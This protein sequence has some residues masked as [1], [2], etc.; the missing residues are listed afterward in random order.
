M[1]DEKQLRDFLKRLE[2]AFDITEIVEQR[3]GLADIDSYYHQS[4]WAYALIHSLD[5][6][7]HMALS[8][9]EHFRHEDYLTQVNIV[10]E[11]IQTFGAKRILELGTGKGFNLKH[12][13][14]KFPTS[15]FFGLDLSSTHI[16][17]S[18]RKLKPYANASVTQAD[19]HYIPHPKHSF[20]YIFEFESICHTLDI[21]KSLEDIHRVLSPSGH[22]TLFDGFRIHKMSALTQDERTAR[23]L[24]EKTLGVQEGL[25]I[26]DFCA[27]AESVGFKVILCDNLS[28]NIMP[29]LKRLQKIQQF[30]LPTAIHLKIARAL[31]PKYLARNTIASLLMPILVD[32]GIQ[33]YYRLT[34]VK[35]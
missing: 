32:A 31:L 15:D 1:S 27:I 19:F 25:L 22:F 29:N 13:V 9:D 17:Q 14:H 21:R 23:F 7:V 26:H 8:D 10:A 30:F 12:L 4:D 20:D 2:S 16:A 33:G 18:H 3:I 6:A 35:N 34:L 11:E 5:G 24:V 28:Q